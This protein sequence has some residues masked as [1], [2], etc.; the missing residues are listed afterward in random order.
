MTD[1]V[2]AEARAR[3]ETHERVCTERYGNIR[4]ALGEIRENM[5]E[6]R[7]T[8]AAAEKSIHDRFNAISG[9]MWAAVAGALVVTVGALGTLVFYL[10]TRGS[11]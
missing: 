3:L 11:H 5:R 9:R 4:S 1:V 8:K 10:L 6:D 7:V 2:D